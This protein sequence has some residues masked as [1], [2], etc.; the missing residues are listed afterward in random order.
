MLNEAVVLPAPLQPPIMY[1]FL[2]CTFKGKEL[3]VCSKQTF[4]AEKLAA[5][6]K[7]GFKPNSL[8]PNQLK[9]LGTPPLKAKALN[10]KIA[11]VKQL[12]QPPNPIVNNSIPSQF[13]TKP[14]HYFYP[15]SSCETPLYTQTRFTLSGS[16]HTII[17]VA[18]IFLCRY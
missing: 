17:V 14:N 15:N 11:Q 3:H 18:T 16:L 4:V 9:A 6:L 5:E 12:L 1:S 8:S 7:S 13:R 2:S 10:R